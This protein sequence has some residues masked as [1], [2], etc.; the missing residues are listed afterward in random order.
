M[1]DVNTAAALLLGSFALMIIIKVPIT[2]ALAVSTSL[3]MLYANVPLMTVVQQMGKSVNTFSL[4]A[5]P[6]FILA[7][8]IMGAGG[9]S[10]RLLKFANVLVGW[11]RGGLAHV[12]VLAS[13]FFGGISGSAVADVSSLGPLEIS[14]ME[15]AG[16]DKDFSVALTVSSSCQAVLIP[17]SH[18]MILYSMAAGGVSVGQLFLGGMLPGVLLGVSLMIICVVISIKRNYPKGS[19]VPLK[20]AL[21]ITKD[22]ILAMMTA[23]I[24]LFGVTSGLFTATESAAIAAVYA[25]ILSVFIY[26]ELK[27]REMPRLLMNCIKILAMVYS[28]I[29]AAG[30][31]GWMLA[32]LKV[33]A[34]ITD[35]L[36][37][38]SSNKI[39]V[40]LLINFMLLI[41][42]C[43]MDMAPLIRIC[44][45]ILLP[46]V[47]S[48][49]MSP[50]QFGCMLILNLAVGLCTPPV[51][52]ALFVGCA[53][54]KLPVEKVAK[55]LLP[56]YTIM[57]VALMLVTFVPAISTWLPAAVYGAPR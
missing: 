19:R 1:F 46:V 37:S 15:N 11:M 49:G 45:P 55:A 28:L 43:I 14:M 35:L 44:T 20:E 7:G 27:I 25:F 54:G 52:S 24:I 29:A 39:V 10:D 23:V 16:Y 2:F 56:M 41:L 12:N 36:L 32:Y 18:N 5:I 42:G 40:F 50:I 3:T 51:G 13:M 8:E 33:P 34:L 57:I 17:P 38:V 4:M 21:I 31:F 53:V 9:I 22:S 26:K 30:A 47:S 48:F 6:F